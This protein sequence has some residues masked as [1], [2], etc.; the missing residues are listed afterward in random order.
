MPHEAT[1]DC[2]SIKVAMACKPFDA[3]LDAGRVGS[4][5]HVAQRDLRAARRGD[6]P[7]ATPP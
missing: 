7:I 2:F 1:R 6:A 4:E 5:Q 3:C